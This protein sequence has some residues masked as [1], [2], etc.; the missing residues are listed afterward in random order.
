MEYDVVLQ[1]TVE[2][3]T[4]SPYLGQVRGYHYLK[5]NQSKHF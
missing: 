5:N 2:L 1:L 4:A 3:T